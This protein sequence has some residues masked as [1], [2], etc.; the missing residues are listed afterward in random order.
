MV[1]SADLPECTTQAQ[2]H[3]D[4]Q[5]L[6]I[7]HELHQLEFEVDWRED[8]NQWAHTIP[9]ARM[10]F[11]TAQYQHTEKKT[12]VLQGRESNARLTEI[13]ERS[14]RLWSF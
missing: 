1:I 8:D 12:L 2:Q 11:D 13:L 4:G 9:S 10:T 6:H 5:L 14:S 3:K 7:C